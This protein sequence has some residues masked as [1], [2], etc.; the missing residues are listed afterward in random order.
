MQS[1]QNEG[2]YQHQATLWQ[3]LTPQLA[4][5]KLA[6]SSP[7]PARLTFVHEVLFAKV[8]MGGSEGEADLNA[9]RLVPS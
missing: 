6:A 7:S 3:Q 1:V 4:V 5:G 9:R 8:W 2:H